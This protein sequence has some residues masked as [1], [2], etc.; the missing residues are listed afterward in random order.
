MIVFRSGRRASPSRSI[1]P[2]D[3]AVASANVGCGRKVDSA[4]QS[5]CGGLRAYCSSTA[6][7]SI[8]QALLRRGKLSQLSLA[9]KRFK[10]RGWTLKRSA[11]STIEFCC[12]NVRA[13]ARCSSSRAHLRPIGLPRARAAAIPAR[14]RSLIRLRSNCASAAI[15]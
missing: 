12:S 14:V 11:T 9:S 13:C 2:A 6:G 10:V 5:R 3:I 7:M 8:V 1:V 15:R 4:T